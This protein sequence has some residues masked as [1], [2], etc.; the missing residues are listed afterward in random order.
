[1]EKDTVIKKYFRMAMIIS[2]VIIGSLLVYLMVVEIFRVKLSPFTGCVELSNPQ[3]IRYI[4]YL[5]AALQ[6]VFIRLLR[7]LLL[8]AKST[9]S[10]EKLVLKLF[11]VS[12]MTSVLAEVPAL[13][14]LALFFLGGFN[15]DFYVLLFV[16]F[17]LMF[18]FFPRKNNWKAWIK[19]HLEYS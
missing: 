5:A 19:K 3:S 17:L 2:G 12:I 1:M 16:S 18:M 13:V 11:R 4:F 6:I 9:D 8:R 7:G 10:E 15:S 14:G